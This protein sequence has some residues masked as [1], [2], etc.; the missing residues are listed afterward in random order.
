MQ[1]RSS[2]FIGAPLAALETVTQY[3]AAS[4]L[5]MAFTR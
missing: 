3:E 1:D 2:K 5:V 4:L